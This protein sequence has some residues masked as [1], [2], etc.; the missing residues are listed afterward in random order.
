MKRNSVSNTTHEL[1]ED[2][3]SSHIVRLIRR[4]I[5]RS[6]V[7]FVTGII[8]V[9]KGK[10]S[11]R[12]TCPICGWTGNRFIRY[13]NGYGVVFPNMEC[14]LCHSHDRHRLFYFYIQHLLKLNNR[15]LHVLHIAPEKQISKLLLQI[16]GIQYVSLDIAPGKAQVQADVEH[17]PFQSGSFDVI[18]CFCVLEHVENDQNALNEL[19][20]VLKPHGVCAIIVPINHYSKKTMYSEAPMTRK[21]RTRMLWQ[22]D[23]VRLY[24]PDF[25]KILKQTGFSVYTYTA[26]SIH[27]RKA[28]EKYGLPAFPMYLCSKQDSSYLPHRSQ[29]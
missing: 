3:K 27:E 26:H 9:V 22:A 12:V 10:E 17:M 18:I 11:L 4:N 29:E 2:V 19:Y 8:R 14:P 20:R 28:A 23:H 21:D 25:P 15:P 13:D 16:P 24:A 5:K 1:L 6:I 7:L